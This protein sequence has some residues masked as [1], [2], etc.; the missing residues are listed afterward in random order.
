M[1]G[2]DAKFESAASISVWQHIQLSKQIHP[3]DTP[4]C[5]K[6]DNQP[7]AKQAKNPFVFNTQPLHTP[8]KLQPCL[9]SCMVKV[10][11]RAMPYTYWTK[12]S[13]S[14]TCSLIKET[15]IKITHTYSKSFKTLEMS[16]HMHRC[17]FMHSSVC[18]CFLL[19]SAFA[20]F[21]ACV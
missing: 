19:W 2:L 20:Q 4:V 17:A 1:N 14:C 8:S 7:T 15:Y 21:C 10:C 9:P 13:G 11:R 3:V 12:K 6:N 5:Y 18:S 16:V